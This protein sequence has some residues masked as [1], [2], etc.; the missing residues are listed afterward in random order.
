VA[1][2]DVNGV[3]LSYE[4]TGTG[5]PV[6][7]IMGSGS[8]GRAWHLHQVP[9]LTAAGYRVI[10]FDNRGI[11]PSDICAT[12]FTVDDLVGDVA[13]LI[14]RLVGGACR[15]VGTS[16]GASVAQELALARPDLVTQ[17]VLMASRCKCDAIGRALAMAEKELYDSGVRLPARYDAVVRAMQS[18]SPRSLDN[19]QDVADWLDLFEL[20][21]RGGPGARAQLGLEPMPDRRRAYA[22]IQVP[23]HVVSFC[24]DLIVPPQRGR[25]LAEAIPGASFDLIPDAGHYGYLENPDAVNKSI[26]EFFR[27]T[28]R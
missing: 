13:G 25:E 19:E 3:R 27:S 14:G 5:E 1:F 16:M 23:C 7:M 10:T 2:A 22:R 20:A 9:A 15:V 12:G 18:L 26:L 6:I 4:D 28:P 21:P 11:P 24:D 17:A 8:G